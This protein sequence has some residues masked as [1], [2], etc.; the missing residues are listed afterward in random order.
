MEFPYLNSISIVNC[1]SSYRK[2]REVDYFRPYDYKSRHICIHIRLYWYCKDL[3]TSG[4]ARDCVWITESTGNIENLG[5]KVMFRG[6]MCGF[7]CD[8]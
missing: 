4:S 8:E 3:V 2:N 5:T 6:K 7:L 1:D